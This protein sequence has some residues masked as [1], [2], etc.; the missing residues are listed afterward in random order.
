MSSLPLSSPPII[1]FEANI[2]LL[3][4]HQAE[5]EE[6]ARKVD[7]LTAENVAI[8]SEISRLSEN[9]EK[10]KKENSTLMVCFFPL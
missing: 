10:L 3:D 1:L 2:I 7:S 9:S 5:T 6:L 4:H 8:R